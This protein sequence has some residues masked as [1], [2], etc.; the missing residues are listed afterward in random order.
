MVQQI[1]SQVNKNSSYC[2][3]QPCKSGCTPTKIKQSI[4]EQGND[5]FLSTKKESEKKKN[6]FKVIAG[7]VIGALA[8]AGTVYA[9]TKGKAKKALEFSKLKN[10]FCN[11]AS[12]FSLAGYEDLYKV[13][14]KEI[15]DPHELNAILKNW[16]ELIRVKGKLGEGIMVKGAW[17][18]LIKK[19]LPGVTDFEKMNETQSAK[20]PELLGE[21]YEQIKK[22]GV[23]RIE[24]GTKFI[25]TDRTVHQKYLMEENYYVGDEIEV[26]TPSWFLSDGKPIEEGLAKVSK[27]VNC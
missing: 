15:V 4:P 8:V 16:N 22:F 5:S 25:A 1:T 24:P 10:E 21:W 13:V 14:N 3:R 7:I 20:I 12:S 2:E 23:A 11:I 19:Y 27:K 18:E 9:V 26:I 6:P 17:D